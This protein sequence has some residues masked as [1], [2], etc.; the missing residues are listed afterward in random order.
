MSPCFNRKNNEKKPQKQGERHCQKEIAPGS[1][2]GNQ[3]GILH[4][5]LEVSRIDRHRLCPTEHKGAG[6]ARYHKNEKPQRID[7]R[8]RVERQSAEHGRCRVA[9]AQ[10]HPAVGHFMQNDAKHQGHKGHGQ[11]A[12]ACCKIQLEHQRTVSRRKRFFPSFTT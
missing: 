2:G 7:M 6:Q 11:M 10:R 12:N 9:T 5:M 8:E 4:Q 3:H 1:G